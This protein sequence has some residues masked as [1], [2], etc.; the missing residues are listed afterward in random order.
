[1]VIG[2]RNFNL[3]RDQVRKIGKIRL[4]HSFLSISTHCTHSWLTLEV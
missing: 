1:M 2:I 3:Q 4:N